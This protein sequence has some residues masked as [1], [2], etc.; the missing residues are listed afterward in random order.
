VHR[1]EEVEMIEKEA[2]LQ[3]ARVRVRAKAFARYLRS[4]NWAASIPEADVEWLQDSEIQL[5]KD[6][7]TAHGCV[8]RPDFKWERR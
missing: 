6:T 5:Y 7:L 1:S 8:Q 3:A 2:V 4:E